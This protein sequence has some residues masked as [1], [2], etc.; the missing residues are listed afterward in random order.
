MRVAKA[1]RRAL[2]LPHGAPD[3]AINAATKPE[4]IQ[5]LSG[6]T[7][8]GEEGLAGPVGLVKFGY[9]LLTFGYGILTCTK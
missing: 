9:D 8:L 3:A 7:E 5:T 1:Q 2:S 6:V 4:T